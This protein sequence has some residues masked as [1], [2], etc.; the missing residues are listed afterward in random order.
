MEFTCKICGRRK[1]IADKGWRVAFETFVPAG[2]DIK[3]TIVV[4]HGWDEQRAQEPNA[5]Y[6]CSKSCEEKYL[7]QWYGEGELAAA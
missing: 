3:R 6:F 1:G 7:S 2:D 4:L 5:M